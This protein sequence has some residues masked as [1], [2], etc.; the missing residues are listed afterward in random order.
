MN[1]T[2]LSHGL[3][4]HTTKEGEIPGLEEYYKAVKRWAFS[5]PDKDGYL[6]P[7]KRIYPKRSN[8]QN[9]AV[10]GL[11]LS[12]IMD[13]SY[14][15]GAWNENDKAYVYVELKKEMGWTR[16]IVNKKTG[17]VVTVPKE[18]RNLEKHEYA[19][20]MELLARHVAL[21]HGINLPPPDKALAVI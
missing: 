11:W 3:F 4:F 8:Q 17:L 18:T 14:G 15:E 20:F 21:N 2:Q 6:Y 12:M 13:D 16:Q 1:R 19:A 7:P 10:M 5:N 9:K